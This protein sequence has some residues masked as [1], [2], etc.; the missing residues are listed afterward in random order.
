MN[1]HSRTHMD[2]RET[3]DRRETQGEGRK[4]QARE[5]PAKPGLWKLLVAS[6]LILVG[7]LAMVGLFEDSG[8]DFSTPKP[9]EQTNDG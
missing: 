7:L 2:H 3:M 9:A 5:R 1:M 4:R 6:A 8:S